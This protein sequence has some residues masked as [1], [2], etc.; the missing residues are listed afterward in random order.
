LVLEIESKIMKYRIISLANKSK[1]RLDKVKRW[2]NYRSLRRRVIKENK[3]LEWA[4]SHFPDTTKDAVNI[5]KL[6][7]MKP[8]S[9]VSY[10]PVSGEFYIVNNDK[11]II[12]T[13]HQINVINGRYNYPVE[14][15]EEMG[16]YLD[17]YLKR[18]VERKRIKI[19]KEIEGK[20]TRS[21]KNIL[22]EVKEV[23]VNEV[24][25]KWGKIGMLDEISDE[26]KPKL[27]NQFEDMAIFLL[28]QKDESK[29][30][31]LEAIIFPVVR[32]IG[33]PRN[34]KDIEPKELL[35]DIGKIMNTNDYKVTEASVMNSCYNNID[36]EAH[37]VDYIISAYIDE[38]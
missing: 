7:A 13:K 29:Y 1:V 25:E 24:L 36:G 6:Q 26:Y 2:F 33:I 27:A 28:S 5:V 38:E 12:L 4:M 3:E 34:F 16:Y 31:N 23:P 9:E 14:I 21:L 32:R 18:I 19:K 30:K 8:T 15:P 20:I 37:M 35:D 22:A 11:Y 10:A 17:K